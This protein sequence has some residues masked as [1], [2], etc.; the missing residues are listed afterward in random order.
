[1]I[2]KVWDVLDC[3]QCIDKRVQGQSENEL[4]VSASMCT[5]YM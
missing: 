3:E 4:W 1:M 5:M 2:P